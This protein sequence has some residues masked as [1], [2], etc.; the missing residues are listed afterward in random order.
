MFSELSFGPDG[1]QLSVHR[2]DCAAT[3]THHFTSCTIHELVS[4]LT[5]YL[6]SSYPV[7]VGV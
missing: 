6:V 1:K 5:Q 7:A 2:G 3:N 4:Y